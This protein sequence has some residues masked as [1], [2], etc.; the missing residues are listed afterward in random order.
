MRVDRSK[1]SRQVD[2]SNAVSGIYGVSEGRVE[3]IGRD[4]TDL[5]SYQIARLGLARTF[6]NTELFSEMTVLENIW[7]G[8]HNSYKT[9]LISTVLRLPQ[10]REEEAAFRQAAHELLVLV[11]L[12]EFASEKA[13]NLPLG[14]QRRL[15]IVRALPLRP[16]LLLLDEP[17]VDFTRNEVE[18]SS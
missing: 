13:R 6:Q 11:G 9:G 16:K 12:E 4:I 8:F 5:K 3:F 1:W 14:F 2:S 7:V 18:R 10:F 15:E 17:A